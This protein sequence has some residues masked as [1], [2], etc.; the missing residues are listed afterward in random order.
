MWAEALPVAG[1]SLTCDRGIFE[2]HVADAQ[3]ILVALDNV[4]WTL[5]RSAGTTLPG[6]VLTLASLPCEVCPGCR[7]RCPLLQDHD[8]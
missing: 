6:E 3:S 4:I 8:L 1:V 5:N 7:S 2:Y